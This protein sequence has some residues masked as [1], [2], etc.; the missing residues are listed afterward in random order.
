[1][2]HILPSS[3]LA[4]NPICHVPQDHPQARNTSRTSPRDAVSSPSHP[5]F[6]RCCQ[7]SQNN[8]RKQP[9]TPRRHHQSGTISPPSA[10]LMSTMRRS[11]SSFS[12]GA[13]VERTLVTSGVIVSAIHTPTLSAL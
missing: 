1:M 13:Q 2:N 7:C 9:T 10:L 8:M 5:P 6:F 12:H 11:A 4:E 3:V